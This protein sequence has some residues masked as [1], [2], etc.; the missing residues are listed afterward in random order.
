MIFVEFNDGQPVGVDICKITF[1]YYSEVFDSVEVVL[2]DDNMLHLD[3]SYEDFVERIKQAVTL[4]PYRQAT[5][6][7]V[8]CADYMD[9]SKVLINLEKVQFFYENDNNCVAV[10]FGGGLGVVIA[11]HYDDFVQKIMKVE[12]YVCEQ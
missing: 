10:D 6:V 1:A 4:A 9:G 11:G 5:P 8:E 3:T 7:F 2:D 12:G